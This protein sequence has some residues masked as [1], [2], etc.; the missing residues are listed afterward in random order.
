MTAFVGSSFK[1]DAVVLQ[2]ESR[3]ER[4]E[5]PDVSPALFD[6]GRSVLKLNRSDWSAMLCFRG[7]KLF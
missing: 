3:P 4:I 1:P 2:V 6:V 7:D 5:N